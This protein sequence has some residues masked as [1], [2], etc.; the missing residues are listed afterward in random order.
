M[1]LDL[2][3]RTQAVILVSDFFLYLANLAMQLCQC[4]T[5]CESYEVK[6]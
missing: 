5:A 2:V 6:L 4:L 1:C 3:F